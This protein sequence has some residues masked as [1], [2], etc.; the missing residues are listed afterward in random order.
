MQ[1]TDQEAEVKADLSFVFSFVS[2]CFTQLAG[3]GYDVGS[4]SGLDYAS[5]LASDSR[6][7]DVSYNFAAFYVC[8]F[9]TLLSFEIR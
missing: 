6:H 2:P 5:A 1:S 9:A 4:A 7:F 8:A 3:F